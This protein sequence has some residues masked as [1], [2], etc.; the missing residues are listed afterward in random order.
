MKLCC[1]HVI[2]HQQLIRRFILTPLHLGFWGGQSREFNVSVALSRS[3]CVSAIQVFG[4]KTGRDRARYPSCSKYVLFVAN[5]GDFEG[6]VL[7][8][9]KNEST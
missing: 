7:H 6:I 4:S 5:H 3:C 8:I 1:H 2:T 9:Q